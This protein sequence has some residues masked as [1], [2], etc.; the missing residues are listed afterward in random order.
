MEEA[1]K[2]LHD[3]IP[4]AQTYMVDS[5]LKLP[6]IPHHGRPVTLATD[7]TIDKENMP[8]NYDLLNLHLHG[9]EVE[10][11]LF[12]PQ[13]TS[14]SDAPWISLDVDECYCYRFR[15][16]TTHPTGT[17]YY[18]P[19]RHGATGM[20]TW[21][22]M[23][24]PFLVTGGLDD[25]LADMTKNNTP[26]ID[27][28]FFMW[29]AHV[30]RAKNH[31]EWEGRRGSGDE[32]TL[33]E[34]DD[35]LRNQAGQAEHIFVMVNNE[36]QPTLSMNTSQVMRI[37]LLCGAS[38][39]MCGFR[40]RHTQ[41]K[42][43][44]PL[45]NVGSDGRTWARAY[46]KQYMILMAS[47]REEI[48][49]Q[50]AEAGL[51]E[52][53]RPSARLF[54][55]CTKSRANGQEFVLSTDMEFAKNERGS[56]EA[57]ITDVEIMG[58]GRID[59]AMNTDVRI[60]PFEQ[61]VIDNKSYN[62]N[63][64]DQMAQRLQVEEWVITNSQPTV[65]PL[66]IHVNPFQVKEVRTALENQIEFTDYITDTSTPMNRWRDT[67]IVPPY[68]SLRIWT[69]YA[70]RAYGKTVFH[71]HFEAHSDTGMM[72]NLMITRHD[73]DKTSGADESTRTKS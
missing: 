33:V 53:T 24:G 30:H 19:H 68:G 41:S 61:Y 45:Y 8:H 17:Y 2:H 69:R 65:H 72:S 31:T 39:N 48:L 16:P 7:F 28:P 56:N 4:T 5:D 26:H 14:K 9:L 50:I 43:I 57:D 49:I 13:G 64:I 46:T 55:G 27:Q 63:R 40:L 66:H 60:L 58:Q 1:T 73:T 21:N 22:G 54:G 23:W 29:D 15:L 51:Y 67:A 70:A 44:V 38:E 6:N 62:V 12:H 47:Q 32:S 34:T 10:T 59:F 11:H 42:V 71:C 37:R 20:Q 35:F 25:D 36:F 18:H 52:A 3:T